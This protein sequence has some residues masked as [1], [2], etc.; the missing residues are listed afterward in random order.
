MVGSIT[1]IDSGIVQISPDNSVKEEL[2]WR[3]SANILCNYMKK[4]TYLQNA[5]KNLAFMPRYVEERMDYL[6]VDGLDSLTFPMTCFCDIPLSKV[7][8]HMKTYGYFGI[9]LK[10]HAC[11]IKDVQPINYVNPNSRLCSD[12]S[13]ALNL[14]YN[15]KSR[16]D[17]EWERVPDALLSQLLYTKP[18]RGT[19]RKVNE[20]PQEL[21]FQDECEWRFIPSE[22]GDL[23]LVLP[24][25]CNNDKGLEVY[26][27]ALAKNPRAWFRFQIEDIEYIIVKNE[28]EAKR[29]ISFIR[30]MKGVNGVHKW[31]SDEKDEMIRRIEIAEKFDKNLV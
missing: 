16:I 15:S 30:R 23:P 28:E 21:L 31:K 5:I 7:G 29:L 14:L 1:D 10:K 2:Q 22:L 26:S 9:A 13:E 3:S 19:M 8:T 18:I 4:P 11:F 25:K 17:P 27:K 20:E 12:I 6:K 24:P